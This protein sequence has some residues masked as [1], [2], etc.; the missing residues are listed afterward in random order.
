[1]LRPYHF[2]LLRSLRVRIRFRIRF[3]S[4]R[5]AGPPRFAALRFSSHRFA[6]KLHFP[7]GP[8]Y[9]AAK[10]RRSILL[11]VSFAASP[12]FFTLR[13]CFITASLCRFALPLSICLALLCVASRS[14][15][16]R[17]RGLL[18][19]PS[20]GP[21]LGLALGLLLGPSFGPLLSPSL[22]PLLDTSRPTEARHARSEVT[23]FGPANCT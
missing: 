2:A 22:G 1:M 17:R 10:W 18:L 3:R 13:L 6:S 8:C 11:L 23:R 9:F 19:G 4:R 7:S 16:T 20:L 15:A 21:L 12:C 5:L 14:L